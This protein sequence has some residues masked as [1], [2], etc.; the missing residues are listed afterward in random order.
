MRLF[1]PSPTEAPG[2]PT[3]AREHPLPSTARRDGLPLLPPQRTSAN[4]TT[5]GLAYNTYLNSNRIYGCKGC[6]THL[7]NH[8]DIIS[9]VSLS[10]PLSLPPSS[11]SFF[12]SSPP[13]VIIVII[14][15]IMTM[16]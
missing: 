10:L 4:S 3:P 5:M 8:E 12:P 11:L 16:K 9:R 2:K 1:P 7:A 13:P 14:I 6:K 15:I